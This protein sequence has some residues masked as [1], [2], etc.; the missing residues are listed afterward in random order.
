MKVLVLESST[1]SA[2]AMLYSDSEGV[3][4]VLT[5]AY[6]A[7]ESDIQTLDPEKVFI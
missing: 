6:T 7:N 5:R 2:K 1:S 3:L 4:K